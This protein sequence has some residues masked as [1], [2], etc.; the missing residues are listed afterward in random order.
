MTK[1]ALTDRALKALKPAPTGKRYDLM[2]GVVPGLGVRVTDKGQRTFVLI[3]R[4][5]G[6][7]NPTRRALGEYGAIT[8]DQARAKARGW[9]EMVQRGTDP[10]HAEER[11]R[12]AAARERENSFAAVAED[13]IARHVSKTRKGAEVER[14]IRREFIDRW[15]DRPITDITRHDVMAVIDAAV[16][17]GAPYQAHNLLGYV[18]RLFNW[19]IA[20]GTCGLERSPC[21]R[22]KP[23]DAIGPK[24]SRKR[25]LTDDELRAFWKCTGDMGYPYGPLFQMLLITGQRESMVCEANRPELD[26][27]K[28]LWS[29]SEERMKS[30]EPFVFP[31]SS[32]ALSI[33]NSL[34]RFNSGE[35]LFSAKFGKTPIRGTALSKPKRRLD[36]AML[37][38]LRRVAAERGKSPAS[39]KLPPWVLHDLRRTMRSGLSALPIAEHVR[40]VV[41]GHVRPGI[42]G[43]YDL[44]AYLDEK[45]QAL[46]LWA[47][48]LRDIVE[49]PPAN[50]IPI[51]T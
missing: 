25:I 13:F 12:Q 34:P 26:L 31:L 29:L 41:I 32:L 8:L 20:R 45:R 43:V 16:D 27:Q 37:A 19:A 18:R 17:R 35:F 14:D 39:V 44:Y 48:R 3:A 1:K 51:A 22:L 28:K 7:S 9:I 47:A 30:D 38:E 11:D 36:A 10:K 49:P 15:G 40:E 21:D 42:S 2:D 50:V 4:Y 46:E 33:A 24:K 6:A 5:P 23:R